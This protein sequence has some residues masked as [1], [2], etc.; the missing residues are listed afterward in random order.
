MASDAAEDSAFGSR[1]ALDEDTLVVGALGDDHAGLDAGG[2]YVFMRSGTVW[3]EVQRLDPM[4][5]GGA[6]EL[7]IDFDSTLACVGPGQ[8]HA[9]S[10]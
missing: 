9:G 7:E 6:L 5:A 8:L 4:D 10:T 2:A 1:G 3:S